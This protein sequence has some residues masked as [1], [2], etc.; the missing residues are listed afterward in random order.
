MFSKTII[1]KNFAN[2]AWS[3]HFDNQTIIIL[4]LHLALVAALNITVSS[5]STK[6]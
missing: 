2:E 5:K 1:R 6:S 3:L 4:I